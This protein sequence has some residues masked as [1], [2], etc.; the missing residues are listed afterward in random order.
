MSSKKIE[1][2]IVSSYEDDS[3]LKMPSGYYV[4]Y[5][6]EVI[7]T[8]GDSYNDRGREKCEAFIFGYCTAKGISIFDCN[9]KRKDRSDFYDIYK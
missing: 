3:R 7:A 6:G 5:K 2:V 8:Y 4:S 1:F 9:I